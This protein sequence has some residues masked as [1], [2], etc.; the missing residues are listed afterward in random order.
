MSIRERARAVRAQMERVATAWSDEVALEFTEFYPQWM[1]GRAYAVGDRVRDNNILYKCVQGHT[2]Q[3]DWRPADT[4]ALWVRVSVEE[5]PEWVQ[6]IGA[7]DAYAKGDKVTH[8]ERRWVSD[9]DGNVWEP[10][11]YGWTEAD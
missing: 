3:D 5:W 1:S 6:P 10:G 2:S 9:Y 7:A 8:N 4:P 11:V